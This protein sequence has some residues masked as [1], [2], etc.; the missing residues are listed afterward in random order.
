MIEVYFLCRLVIGKRAK[1]D[2]GGTRVFETTSN[3]FTWMCKLIIIEDRRH[4]PLFCERCCHSRRVAC[5]PTP[6]PFFCYVSRRPTSAG[7]IHNQIT[8]I[9]SHQCTSF[10]H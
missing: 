5:Y 1:R 8:W 2:M 3:A 9:S 7:Y 4:Q 6:S 10:Y